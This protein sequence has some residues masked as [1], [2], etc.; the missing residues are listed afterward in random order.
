MRFYRD[1][2]EEGEYVVIEVEEIHEHSA[3]ASIKGYDETGLIHISEV[4]RSW[5]RDIK[6]HVDEG[7][8]TVAQ[9]VEIE[10][11]ENSKN[12]SDRANSSS[13]SSGTINLSLKR[14]NDAQKREAMDEWN[15]EEK[16][17]KFLQNVADRTDYTV[18]DLYEAVAFP[19][20]KEYGST[21]EGFEH[22][23]MEDADFEALGIDGALADAVTA[24]AQDNISL[25]Q[26]EMEGEMRIEVPGGNGIDAIKDALTVGEN[27]EVSYIS[28]PDYAITAWGRNAEDARDTMDAA[29]D[30]ITEKVEDAG[31]T[32]QFEKK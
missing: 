12:S 3:S 22:A 14:V 11:S 29:V 26:V 9:V 30:T 4:S 6:Q 13:S 8:R 7:E 17:D 15:K 18:D 19:F 2:P 24:V 1:L 25:K 21:F 23:A 31:G 20:Q 27:V 10:D 28:A 5:V 16:A 32:V